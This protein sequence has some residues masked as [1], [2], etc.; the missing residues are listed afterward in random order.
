VLRY[1]EIAKGDPMRGALLVNVSVAVLVDE[2][3]R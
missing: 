3:R 2:W 1:L